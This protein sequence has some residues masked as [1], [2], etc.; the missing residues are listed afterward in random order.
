MKLLFSLPV[1]P[2][3]P[4]TLHIRFHAGP[5]SRLGT[6]L[7]V[8]EL[9]Q[10]KGLFVEGPQQEVAIFWVGSRAIA[11]D[12]RME[13]SLQCLPCERCV[14]CGCGHVFVCACQRFSHMAEAKSVSAVP[15]CGPPWNHIRTFYFEKRLPTPRA[16]F[17]AH[18]EGR[19]SPLS[20]TLPNGLFLEQGVKGGPVRSTN[21]SCERRL[22]PHHGSASGP[23]PQASSQ[24]LLEEA[25]APTPVPDNCIC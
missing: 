6:N 19:M 4:L 21:F 16:D 15:D 14:R 10:N 24:P 2:A 23:A 8:R 5:L 3:S 17:P 18:G 12:V 11:L 1:A 7:W 13:L 22:S 25:R 20:L 9:G